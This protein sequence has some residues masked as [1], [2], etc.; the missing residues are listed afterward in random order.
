M[1]SILGLLL[2]S[3]GLLSIASLAGI[4]IGMDS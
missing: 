2:F 4:G 1:L 3:S